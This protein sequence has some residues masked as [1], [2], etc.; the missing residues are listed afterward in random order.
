MRSYMR[1]TLLAADD[2]RRE[3]SGYFLEPVTLDDVL[4]GITRGLDAG[5]CLDEGFRPFQSH[6][7]LFGNFADLSAAFN[8]AVPSARAVEVDAFMRD[9]LRTSRQNADRKVAAD[10]RA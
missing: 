6:G 1:T 7:H 9:A 4:A 10:P 2:P 5:Y 3:G 8:V